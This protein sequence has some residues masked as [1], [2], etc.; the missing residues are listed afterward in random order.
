MAM[1]DQKLIVSVNNRRSGF[2][3]PG[4]GAVLFRVAFI[5]DEAPASPD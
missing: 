2:T 4:S 1:K 3:M 5:F